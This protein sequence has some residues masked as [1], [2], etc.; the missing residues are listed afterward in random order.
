MSGQGGE[1][2]NARSKQEFRDRGKY[3][4]LRWFRALSEMSGCFDTS[5]P[6]RKPI[7]SSNSISAT[8]T[9][10]N[11][12]T[13]NLGG[14]FFLF[15]FPRC[16]NSFWLQ[17]LPTKS[18]RAVIDN[19]KF[20]FSWRHWR[21]PLSLSKVRHLQEPNSKNVYAYVPT[22]N[23]SGPWNLV[24]GEKK[25]GA[26]RK[27]FRRRQEKSTKKSQKRTKGRSLQEVKVLRSHSQSWSQ[28]QSQSQNQKRVYLRWFFHS[29][30][31]LLRGHPSRTTFTLWA[32]VSIADFNSPQWQPSFLQV[33]GGGGGNGF[34]R[35]RATPYSILLRKKWRRLICTRIFC[36]RTSLTW[37]RSTDT[38]AGSLWSMISW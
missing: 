2:V 11:P 25:K 26:P 35:T 29:Q 33:M 7:S 5:S 13:S 17:R 31:V 23:P 34:S 27:K 14:I 30:K 8:S 19:L 4:G 9:C 10:T 36:R 18:I 22:P 24:P 12:P 15:L 28:N 20:F 32:T 16:S 1:R 21:T 37:P 3:D 38:A 6:R